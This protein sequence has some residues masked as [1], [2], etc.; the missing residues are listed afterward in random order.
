MCV[1]VCESECVSVCDSVCGVNVCVDIS[2][3]VCEKVSEGVYVF[4]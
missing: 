1:S 4:V 3:F 2:A